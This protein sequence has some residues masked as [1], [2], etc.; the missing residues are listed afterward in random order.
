M[1]E[2]ISLLGWILI[3]FLILL[4]ISVNMSL[5]L[6]RKKNRNQA[7]WILKVTSAGKELKDPFH[8]EEEKLS[9]L[10]SRVKQFKNTGIEKNETTGEQNED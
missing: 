8:K 4:I 10:A 6:G 9:E 1:R 7:E 5:F 3:I 2:P